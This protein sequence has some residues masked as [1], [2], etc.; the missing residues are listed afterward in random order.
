MEIISP[1]LSGVDDVVVVFVVINLAIV[2]VIV[3]V[4]VAVMSHVTISMVINNCLL[5]IRSC[6]ITSIYILRGD[7]VKSDSSTFRVS[8]LSTIQVG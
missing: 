7:F 3:F 1:I 4:V 8:G 2:F 5:S 6:R